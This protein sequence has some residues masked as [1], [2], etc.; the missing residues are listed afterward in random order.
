MTFV[1]NY[2]KDATIYKKEMCKL[3]DYTCGRISCD[4]CLFNKNEKCIRHEI[5]HLFNYTRKMNDISAEEF[6][7]IYYTMVELTKTGCNKKTICG[8]CCLRQNNKC[9]RAEIRKLLNKK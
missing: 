2:S 6:D 5:A 7:I 3:L 1:I 8:K 9:V 4:E